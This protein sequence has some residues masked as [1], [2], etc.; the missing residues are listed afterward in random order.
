MEGMWVWPQSLAC[1]AGLRFRIRRR[2]MKIDRT[3][4]RSRV[5]RRIFTLFV[6]CALLP[7]TALAVL[8][9]NQV[10]KQLN[11][12]GESRLRQATRAVGV[13][14]LERLTV[15]EG[16]MILMS[17]DAVRGQKL[18]AQGSLNGFDEELKTRF[19][20]MALVPDEGRRVPLLGFMQDP[21]PVTPAE[22]DHLLLGYSLLSSQPVAGGRARVLMSRALDPRDPRRGV[23]VGEINT[24]YLWDVGEENTLP[25]RT[26]LCVVEQP[27]TVLFCSPNLPASF[28]GKVAGKILGVAM[29]QFE[30]REEAKEYVAR[31]WSLLLEARFHAPKWTVVLSES[32]ADVL[33]PMREFKKIF[34]LVILLAL[35]VVLLLSV[36]QR[37]E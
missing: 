5:A 3:F 22:R 12:Q 23:L 31:Y 37:S 24:T 34:P 8:S 33:A 28:A 16:L 25:S 26:E 36:S 13:A 19:L 1:R 32:K 27:T 4:L 11:Q 15:L 30:W 20:A 7:I 10:A 35:W 21:P 14:I 18:T 2:V 9:F 17:S 6:L 29:G